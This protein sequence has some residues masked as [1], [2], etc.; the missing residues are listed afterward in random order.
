MES[1]GLWKTEKARNGL[2]LEPPEGS[3]PC[4]RPDFSP[5]RP[6]LD[7]GLLEGQHD[8]HVLF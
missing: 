4:Q 1:G 6:T 5:V 3:Q 8:K 7:F 2:S